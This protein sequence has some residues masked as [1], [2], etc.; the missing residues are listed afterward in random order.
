MVEAPV[1]PSAVLAQRGMISGLVSSSRAEWATHPP[2]LRFSRKCWRSF[3][4]ASSRG[5]F[6]WDGK[7]FLIFLPKRVPSTVRT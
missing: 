4:L 2:M 7:P 1:G 3:V 5:R 6:C